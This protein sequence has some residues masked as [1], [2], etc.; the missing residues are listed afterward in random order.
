MK[1]PDP[2]LLWCIWN[3]CRKD[4]IEYRFKDGHTEQIKRSDLELTL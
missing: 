1:E 2:K 3:D 4:Y